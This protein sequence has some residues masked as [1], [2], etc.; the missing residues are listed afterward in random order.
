MAATT[1]AST[2]RLTRALRTPAWASRLA[3][4]IGYLLVGFGYTLF[5][6]GD[7]AHASA[8]GAGDNLHFMNFLAWTPHAVAHLQ[9]PLFMQALNYPQGVNLAWNTSIPLGGVLIWPVTATLGPAVAYNVFVLGSITLDGWCTYLW[10]RRHVRVSAAAFLGGLLLALGPFIPTHDTQLNLLSFWPVPLM[11]MAVENLV[12]RQSRRWLWGLLLGVLAAAELY[13]SAELAA[14]ALITIAVGLAVAALAFHAQLRRRAAAAI[15]ALVMSAVVFAGLA[16]PL[17]LYQLFGPLHIN[18]PVQPSNFYVTDLQNFVVATPVTWLFPHAL[19]ATQTAA[20]TGAVEDTAYIGIPLALL[21]VYATCRWWRDGVVLTAAITTAVIAVLSLGP[22]L[23]VGGVDT[24]IRLPMIVL[25]RLPL[26]D[27]VVPARFSLMMD[28]GLALLLS[29]TLD[30]TLFGRPAHTWLGSSLAV[31]AV[32]STISLL[33]L[34]TSSVTV[35][36][37]FSASGAVTTLPRGSVALVGP[38]IDADP[39]SAAPMVWQAE[40]DFRFSLIDGLAIT[41][42]GHGHELFLLDTPMLRAFHDIQTTGTP[43]PETPELRTSLLEL[44]HNDRVTVVLLGPMPH[45]DAARQFVSWLL[46]YGPDETQGVL[47]WRGIPT[48]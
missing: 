30:R 29:I 8:G 13:L 10:L 45:R 25:S 5:V 23:H 38:Y 32:A 6:W 36:A 48:V 28:F 27:N 12:T 46:G 37:Y 24:G 9:N 26:L 39:A 31:L 43:P 18:G 1:R 4:F 15:P 41:S 20:W 33:P 19:T 11:F 34:S 16:A 7:P 40:S 21:A 22:H 2:L 35:P 44:L 42:D 47:L 17:L 3:P 14:L